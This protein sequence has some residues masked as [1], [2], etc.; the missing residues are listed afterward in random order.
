MS[1]AATKLDWEFFLSDLDPATTPPGIPLPL[2]TYAAARTFRA[3]WIYRRHGWTAAHP[4]LRR[5]RPGPG[6][7]ALAALPAGTA[8]RLARREIFTSQLIHRTVIPD[9]LCL[10]RS[11]ALATYLSAL[12]LPAQVTIAR[13]RTVA[14]PKNSF[15]SW[16]ELYGTVLNDNP[17][18]QLGYAVLQRVAA[19]QA[20]AAPRARIPSTTE[21]KP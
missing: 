17:D 2:R 12:G 4:Y 10:P 3:L 21:G 13:L 11:L 16:T 5:L 15:H 20:P 19:S 7:A 8:L 18:V 9:G 6:S 14:M 1:R